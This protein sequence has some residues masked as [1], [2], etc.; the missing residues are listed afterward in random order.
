[1]FSLIGSITATALAVTVSATGAGATTPA[2]ALTD[3]PAAFSAL[4][5]PPPRRPNPT[6]PRR[7]HSKFNNLQQCR[8]Q[9]SREH[10]RQPGRWDC[11]RGP[12]RF[13]PWEYWGN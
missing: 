5:Q 9:A 11:R 6:P 13:H 4:Q 7:F 1:M 12:D 8:A 3:V 2:V 10:P